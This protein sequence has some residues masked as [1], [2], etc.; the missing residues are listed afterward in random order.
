MESI[1]LTIKEYYLFR[2]LALSLKIFFDIISTTKDKV[3]ILVERFYLEQL[4]YI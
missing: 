3:K 2:E 1:T 4:G